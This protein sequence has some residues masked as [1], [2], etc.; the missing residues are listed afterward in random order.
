NAVA[1]GLSATNLILVGDQMQLGQPMQGSHPG[2]TGLSCLEYALHGRPTIPPDRGV[3]LGTSFRMHP[4]ICGFI[5][6]AIY[7]GRLRSQPETTN[8]RVVALAGARVQRETGIVFLPVD[9]D[10]CKQSSEEEVSV[11]EDLVRELKGLQ[12]VDKAG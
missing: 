7:E 4:S 1:M 5:S 12:F 10:G 9:H 6:D 3:F 11:I 8:Q 2:E